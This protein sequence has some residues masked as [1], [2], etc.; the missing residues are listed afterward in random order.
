MQRLER[1][2]GITEAG[3][4][5]GFVVVFPEAPGGWIDARPERGGSERDIAFIEALLDR[6]RRTEGA[7]AAFAI[8]V[9]NGGLFLFRMAMERPLR[10]AAFATLLASIPA[11]ALRGRSEGP[12]VPVALVFGRDDPLMPWS[13]GRIPHGRRPGMGVGGIVVPAETTLDYW[14][15]RNHARGTPI[16]RRTGGGD[17]P[18]EIRDYGPTTPAG[19]AVRFVAI[20]GWGHQWPRWPGDAPGD[21]GFDI[22]DTIFEFF[23]AQSNGAPAS[24]HK[25]VRLRLGGA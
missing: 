6:L 10:F 24:D 15:T 20:D 2:S 19:A 1:Q 18:V 21:P 25:P 14:L 9:S 13:G 5:H 3:L 7:N 11:A 22:A 8:G 23:A 17:N 4:R 16:V 12:P